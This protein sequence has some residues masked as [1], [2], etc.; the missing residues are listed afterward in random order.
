MLCYHLSSCVAR[1]IK[2]SECPLEKN[3]YIDHKMFVQ[4][5][6]ECLSLCQESVECRFYYWYPIDYSPK[7]MYCYL[8]RRCEQIK[9]TLR[10][11]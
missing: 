7:P 1:L 2:R 3:N 11:W 8:F 4:S 10:G 6:Q 5:D 9:A